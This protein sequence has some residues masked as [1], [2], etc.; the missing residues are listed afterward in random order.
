METKCFWVVV[1]H[2]NQKSYYLKYVS[3]CLVSEKS[4]LRD[5]W[6]FL[7]KGKKNQKN[8]KSG[9]FFALIVAIFQGIQ[10]KKSNY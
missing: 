9:A 5:L 10:V 3:F 2:Q 4:F 6:V 7:Q 1:F 8:R